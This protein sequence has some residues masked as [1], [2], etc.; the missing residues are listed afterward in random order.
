MNELK[1]LEIKMNE[2]SKKIELMI[3]E[4]KELEEE[5]KSHHHYLMVNKRFGFSNGGDE[6]LRSLKSELVYLSRRIEA[7]GWNLKV[8]GDEHEKLTV[9]N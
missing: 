6:R 7:E 9:S 4:R 5:F 1:D 8:M 2:L 3:N